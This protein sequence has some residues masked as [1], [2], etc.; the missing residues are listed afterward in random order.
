MKKQG[1][2]LRIIT[3]V[4]TDELLSLCREHLDPRSIRYSVIDYSATIRPGVA[5]CSGAYDIV[6]IIVSDPSLLTVLIYG[7]IFGL[8]LS[9]SRVFG[10]VVDAAAGELGKDLYSWLKETLATAIRKVSYRQSRHVNPQGSVKFELRS[11]LRVGRRVILLRVDFFYNPHDWSP[12]GTPDALAPQSKLE[13]MTG[14]VLGRL[15]PFIRAA[16]SQVRF[17]REPTEIDIECLVLRREGI[18]MGLSLNGGPGALYN[19][20]TMRF[21]AAGSMI[22]VGVDPTKAK[23]QLQ[24]IYQRFAPGGSQA[25]RGT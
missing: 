19:V 24:V 5:R 25:Q 23:E 14:I 15:V 8:G 18:A 20:A 12:E 11:H 9:I 6:Q 4:G 2:H 21:D 17:A 13:D 7:V 16:I 10:K 1:D 22:D 3:S